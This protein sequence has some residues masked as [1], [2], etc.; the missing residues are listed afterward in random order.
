VAAGRQAPRGEVRFAP[1]L[2]DAF[3]ILVRVRLF[4][5]RVLQELRGNRRRGEAT[6]REVVTLV[7]RSVQTI[8]VASASLSSR[9]TTSL[10]AP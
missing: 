8:S 10:F 6:R 9:T 7:E 2:H 5:V 3:R 4:L 1:Q